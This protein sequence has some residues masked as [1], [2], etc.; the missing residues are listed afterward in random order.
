MKKSVAPTIEELCQGLVDE[1][2]KPDAIFENINSERGR[3]LQEICVVINPGYCDLLEKQFR[4]RDRN[5]R[6]N[7]KLNVI[8]TQLKT[9]IFKAVAQRLR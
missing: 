3:E 9:H 2:L 4:C 1:A 5:A 8:E 7:A 6:V